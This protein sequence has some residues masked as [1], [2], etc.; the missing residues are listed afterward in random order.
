M[1]TFLTR[2]VFCFLIQFNYLIILN[3]FHSFMLQSWKIVCF[4]DL[5]ISSN[6]SNLLAYNCSQYSLMILC[7]SVLSVVISPLSF[8]ILFNQILFFPLESGQRLVNLI[9]L[10]KKQLLVLLTCLYFIISALIFIISFLLLTL[11]FIC[12]WFPSLFKYTFRLLEIFL[13]S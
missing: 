11:D 1:W 9:Y 8:L 5:S 10:L 7:I 13:V 2:R 4:Q 3:F 12:S 6:F